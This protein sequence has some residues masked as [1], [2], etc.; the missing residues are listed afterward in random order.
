MRFAVLLPSMLTGVFIFGGFFYVKYYYASFGI[1][2]SNFFSISDYIQASVDNFF[3]LVTSVVIPTI[4]YCLVAVGAFRKLFLKGID[5]QNL[6]EKSI[7]EL[8]EISSFINK[9]IIQLS[10]GA[11]L[12]F[13]IFGTTGAYLFFTF[14]YST[15][16]NRYDFLY[17][18]GIMLYTAVFIIILDS[19]LG[20]KI[21]DLIDNPYKIG[22]ILLLPLSLLW[23][24]T[25]A[26]KDSDISKLIDPKCYYLG[27]NAKCNPECGEPGKM[28]FVG[29]TSKY[30]FFFEPANEKTSVVNIDAVKYLKFDAT[31]KKKRNFGYIYFPLFDKKIFMAD[32]K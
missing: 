13:I 20:N 5:K 21:I 28:I 30:Y 17:L 19:K 23:I 3:L 2:V 31:C 24:Y 6:K 10:F 25:A 15:A 11:K 8:E 1:A 29:A 32:I 27:F 4:L 18:S 7:E 9:R 16:P 22:A 14:I 12:M 26:K